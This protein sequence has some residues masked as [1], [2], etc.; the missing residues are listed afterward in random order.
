MTRLDKVA[1]CLRMNEGSPI[2]FDEWAAAI[3]ALYAEDRRELVGLLREGVDA[4]RTYNRPVPGSPAATWC[5]RARIALAAAE[6]S[7]P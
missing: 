5:E 3:D 7:T 6:G 4:T 2:T 1:H